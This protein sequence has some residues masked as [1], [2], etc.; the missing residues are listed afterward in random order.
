MD[1]SRLDFLLSIYDDADHDSFVLYGIAKEYEYANKTQD[2]IVTYKKLM[3][4]DPEYVGLYYQLAKIYESIG[5]R[6]DAMTTYDE[7]IKMAKKLSDFHA[8]S[9]LVN[10]R[11]N[12]DIE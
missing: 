1:N 2:A 9:E 5:A 7:G 10:A 6:E 3:V 12:L 11:Q 8:L 4:K